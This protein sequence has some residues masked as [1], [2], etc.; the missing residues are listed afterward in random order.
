MI[1]NFSDREVK[2]S[3]L[4]LITRYSMER[5]SAW[6]NDMSGWSGL[7]CVVGVLVSQGP[8]RVGGIPDPKQVKVVRSSWIGTSNSY[9]EWF[10]RESYV[11]FSVYTVC[12]LTYWVY[13]QR[14]NFVTTLTHPPFWKWVLGCP[15]PPPLND[16][17]KKRYPLHICQECDISKQP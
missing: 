11:I 3:K 1:V 5:M 6:H 12:L 17:Y 2:Y 16:F 9:V 8:H 13:R 14:H 10:F 7:S 15:P 4:C